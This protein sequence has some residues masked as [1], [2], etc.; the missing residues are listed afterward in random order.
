MTQHNGFDPLHSHAQRL[1]GASIPSLIAAEPGRAQSLGMRVGP[2]YVNFARQKYDRAALDA[3]LQ[4]A[5]DELRVL[6]ELVGFLLRNDRDQ[7]IALSQMHVNPLKWMGMAFLGLLTLI[8][9]A[10]VHVEHLRAA[11]TA[12]GLSGLLLNIPLNY[13]LIYG[14]FGLPAMGLPLAG[15][16]AEHINHLFVGALII[17]FLIVEP[18][19][20]A[21]LWQIAKEKLRVWPFPH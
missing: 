16:T 19:G 7:R 13:A 6:R 4:L 12:I 20:L 2:L 21:R 1:R 11:A 10:V 9:I 17:F 14:H 3:L 18:H 5:A 15:A 8:S